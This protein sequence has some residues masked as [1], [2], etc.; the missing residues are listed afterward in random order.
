MNDT[1]LFDKF[2]KSRGG[3][4]PRSI[5]SAEDWKKSYGSL[6]D[7][8]EQLIANAR[9]H[10]PGLPPIYFDFIHNQS[11]NELTFKAEGKYFIAFH[12]GTRYMLELIFCRMLSD[13]RN[14]T[15]SVRENK[16]IPA[17]RTSKLS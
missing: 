8:A 13:V 2:T 9:E 16:I 5:F 6:I 1:I 4:V 17:D 7:R 14:L 15:V 10:V 12:T 3:R 11:I